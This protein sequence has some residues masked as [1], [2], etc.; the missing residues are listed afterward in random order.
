MGIHSEGD[1]DNTRNLSCAKGAESSPSGAKMAWL[2]TAAER[3]TAGASSHGNEAGPDI[4]ENSLP[5]EPNNL[6]GQ[7][8]Y[9]SSSHTG[10]DACLQ[11][12]S[13][14]QFTRE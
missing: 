6:V 1:F 14:N 11:P 7:E 8:P 2:K 10:E 5:M 13:D 12:Y 3:K 9:D 4:R